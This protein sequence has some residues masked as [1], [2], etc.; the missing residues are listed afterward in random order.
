[1]LENSR[2]TQTNQEI[3][4]SARFFSSLLEHGALDDVLMLAEEFKK[5]PVAA[6]YLGGFQRFRTERKGVLDQQVVDAASREARVARNRMHQQLRQ[7]LKGMAMISTNAPLVGLFGT[8]IGVLNSFGY[9]GSASG[10]ISFV[11]TNIANA[12]VPTAAGLLIGVLATWSYNWRSDRLAAC[13]A[14]KEIAS[15]ELRLRPLI[16]GCATTQPRAFGPPRTNMFATYLSRARSH[17]D[18]ATCV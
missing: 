3:A 1:M 14:E 15:A 7:G 6:I 9:I 16:P 12:L 5:S 13:N 2:I 10:Y 17:L 11:A 4:G 8:T 18:F